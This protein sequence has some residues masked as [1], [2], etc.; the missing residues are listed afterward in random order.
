MDRVAWRATVHG[1]K[2]SDVTESEHG[3]KMMDT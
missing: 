1:H 3:M 2:E